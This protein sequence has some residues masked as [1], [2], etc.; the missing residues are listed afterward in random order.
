M[1]L[2]LLVAMALAAGNSLCI[3]TCLVEEC[4][5]TPKHATGCPQHPDP[6]KH[7]QKQTLRCNPHQAAFVS[8]EGSPAPAAEFVAIVEP[9]NP[10]HD[11]DGGAFREVV[12]ESP[13]GAFVLRI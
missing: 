12:P 3:G 1:R 11:I 6:L 2:F 13:P 10:V 7:S 8:V 4:T 9:A 5:A